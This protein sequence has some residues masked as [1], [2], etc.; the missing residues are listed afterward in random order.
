MHLWRPW[1]PNKVVAGASKLEMSPEDA[2]K[3]FDNLDKDRSGTL[4]KEEASFFDK[5]WGRF[6][7]SSKS[8]AVR[9]ASAQGGPNDGKP[10]EPPP[11]GQ[12][13]DVSGLN[14]LK[15][16]EVVWVTM[17]AYCTREG[18]LRPLELFRIFDKDRDGK[19]IYNC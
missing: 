15:G 8:D 19:V 10:F 5:T 18:N 4:T 9:G 2:D 16:A 11:K 3:L 1:Y 7:G 12:T 14:D 6:R 17:R 13:T